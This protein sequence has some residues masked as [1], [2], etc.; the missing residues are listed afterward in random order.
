MQADSATL[1]PT[2]RSRPAVSTTSVRP[3]AMKKVRLACLQHVED[4]AEAQEGIAEHGEHRADQQRR[5]QAIEHLDRVLRQER[6][7]RRDGRLWRCRSC[8][9]PQ[10]V[11][12]EGDDDEDADACDLHRGRHRDQ[13]EPV[14]QH[15]DREH[16]EQRAEQPAI[17]ALERGAADARRRRWRRIRGRGPRSD[18]RNSCA[19]SS[20]GRRCPAMAPPIA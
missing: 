13:V 14:A 10:A 5:E 7:G 9:A 4:V 20:A 11:E 19:R 15:A 8:A 18:G 2:E 3:E 6:A 1:A 12:E 16:A 17:A